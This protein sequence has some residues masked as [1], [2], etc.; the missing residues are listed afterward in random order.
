VALENKEKPED[1]R[2]GFIDS[3]LEGGKRGV[4]LWALSLLPGA[5]FGFAVIE[6]LKITGAL[7]LLAKV[8]APVMGVF[9]LPG[10][11]IS[12]WLTSFLAL[13]GGCAAVVSLVSGGVLDARQVA[14]MIPMMFMVSNQVQYLGRIL[15]V[16]KVESRKYIVVCGIAIFCSVLDGL[17]MNW[18]L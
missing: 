18:L 15:A 2:K 9:G 5:I 16:S 4:M 11:A 10:E 13:P 14:I 8:F 17:L 12:A 1:S 7:P 3:F 6:V